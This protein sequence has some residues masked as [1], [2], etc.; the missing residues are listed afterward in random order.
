MQPNYPQA[1]VTQHQ[2]SQAT[3]NRAYQIAQPGGAIGS[4]VN[5][6]NNRQG[7]VVDT[8]QYEGEAYVLEEREGQRREIGVNKG[9]SVIKEVTTGQP[10]LVS[11]TM[12]GKENEK[13]Y[14]QAINVTEYR[15]NI[16]QQIVQ[17]QIEQ[18]VER[19]VVMERFVDRHFDVIVQRPV[20]HYTEVEIPYDVIYEREVEHI[21]ER[22]VVTEKILEIPIHRHIEIPYEKIIEFQVA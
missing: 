11:E 6:G 17:K 2:Q 13:V 19:P 7:T 5:L 3:N 10:Y 1:S 4:T 9:A 16:R 14:E 12:I 18:V 21:I 22:D 15:P 20:A 8:R